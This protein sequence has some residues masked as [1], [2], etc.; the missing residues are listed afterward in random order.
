MASD[1]SGRGLGR[2]QRWCNFSFLDRLIDLAPVLTLRL[3]PDELLIWP[4]PLT[5]PRPEDQRSVPVERR[6]DESRGRRGGCDGTVFLTQR[7]TAAG[8]PPMRARREKWLQSSHG[9]QEGPN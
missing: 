7:N 2:R 1:S 6:C 8:T 5:E 3:C 4:E 9:C